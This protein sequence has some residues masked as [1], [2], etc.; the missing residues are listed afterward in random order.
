MIAE[1]C[2]RAQKRL[3]VL[4]A[5]T[6]DTPG[7]IRDMRNLIEVAAYGTELRHRSLKLGEFA[8]RYWR[9]RS[10]MRPQYD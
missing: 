8:F 2:A 1:R 9:H 10:Q 7:L 5:Q 4:A 6:G 3:Q